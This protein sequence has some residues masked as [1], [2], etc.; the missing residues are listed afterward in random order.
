MQD[1]FKHKYGQ[2]VNKG[3]CNQIVLHLT[4]QATSATL[5][6]VSVDHHNQRAATE[7]PQTKKKLTC[8]TRWYK[9][10]NIRRRKQ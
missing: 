1:S 9:G 8:D 4:Q 2:T 7:D 10:E 3:S 5:E 6:V